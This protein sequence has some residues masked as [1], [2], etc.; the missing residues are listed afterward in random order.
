[1]LSLRGNMLDDNLAL[2]LSELLR[3]NNVL[4]DLDLGRN[5]LGFTCCY[6]IAEGLEINRS[7]KIL[8]FDFIFTH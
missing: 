5:R 8:R 6:A 3:C 2:S 1:M 4:E 7:L